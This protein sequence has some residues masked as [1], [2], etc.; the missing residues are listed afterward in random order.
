M[1]DRACF[2]IALVF[3]HQDLIDNPRY[4]SWSRGEPGSTVTFAISVDFGGPPSPQELIV[5]L[6]E[7]DSDKAALRAIDELEGKKKESVRVEK[8]KVKNEP[9]AIKRVAEGDEEIE[10]GGKKYKCH[11]VE[12]KSD[13]GATWDKTWRFASGQK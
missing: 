4:P 12:T 5:I 9:P 1:A 10:I 3:L 11:W 6:K 7:I 13:D 8:A 2:V